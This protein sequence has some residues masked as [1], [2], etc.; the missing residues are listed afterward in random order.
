[1]EQEVIKIIGEPLSLA[2]GVSGVKFTVSVNYPEPLSLET[3]RKIERYADQALR[4]IRR[5][6]GCLEKLVGTEDSVVARQ[7]IARAFEHGVAANIDRQLLAGRSTISRIFPFFSQ[8]FMVKASGEICGES[9][10][11]VTS[12]RFGVLAVSLGRKPLQANLNFEEC[13]DS[14]KREVETILREG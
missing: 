7:T 2:E 8:G 1:M 6:C 11:G 10:E 13:I 14:A 5:H 9:D 3:A 4:G 12:I